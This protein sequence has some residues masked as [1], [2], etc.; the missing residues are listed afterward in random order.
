MYTN[1]T[2]LLG[3]V[4]ITSYTDPEIMVPYLL[5][6][7]LYYTYHPSGLPQVDPELDYWPIVANFASKPQWGIGQEF[8]FE[9]VPKA[10]TKTPIIPPDYPFT[11]KYRDN[12]R[13][14]TVCWNILIQSIQILTNHLIV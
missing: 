3:Y 1:V 11:P 12:L 9:K 14:F 2:Q 4:G 13:A 5:E 6:D 7:I 8:K 10:V